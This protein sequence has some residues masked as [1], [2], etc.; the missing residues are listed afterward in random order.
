MLKLLKVPADLRLHIF[1]CYHVNPIGGHFSLYHTYHRIRLRYYWPY[2][3]KDIKY[4]ISIY[5]SCT[6]NHRTRP[7]TELL[8][9]FLVDAPFVTVH[10]DVWTPGFI[11]LEPLT[12]VNAQE[13][14][15]SLFTIM[16][17]YR[18]SQLVITDPDTKF[19][20]EFKEAMEMLKIKHHMASRGHHNAVLVERFNVFLNSSL[21]IFNNGRKSNRPFV[22]GAHLS[23]YAWN[24]A[25]VVGTD[26]SRSLL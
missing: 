1:T 7:Q 23:V 13:F 24:S 17:R 15:C 8:Y 25:P 11:A 26:I 16:L 4:N 6:L 14:A 12:T 22:E 19:K 20:G 10:A 5:A 21:T 9:T 3:Y 18:I 2:M